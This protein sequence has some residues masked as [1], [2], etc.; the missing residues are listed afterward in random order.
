MTETARWRL[1]AVF[2]CAA[3]GGSQLGAAE[4]QRKQKLQLEGDVRPILVAHCTACHGAAAPAAELNMATE[5]CLMKGCV[6]GPRY[7]TGC[8][9]DKSPVSQD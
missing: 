6:N 5:A 3:L 9:K 1:I 4:G 7:H 8:S 2:I